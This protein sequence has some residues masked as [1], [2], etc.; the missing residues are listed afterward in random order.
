M[1]YFIADLR[2]CRHKRQLHKP[3]VHQGT[4]GFIVAKILVRTEPPPAKAA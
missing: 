4:P 3:G 2:Y 1:T